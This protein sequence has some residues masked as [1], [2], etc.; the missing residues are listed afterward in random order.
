MLILFKGEEHSLMLDQSLLRAPPQTLTITHI[1]LELYSFVTR[2]VNMRP[3][4]ASDSQSHI[5]CD[6]VR[7]HKQIKENYIMSQALTEALPQQLLTI[8]RN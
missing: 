6:T 5:R 7:F 8:Q 2:E 1:P 3:S 4:A